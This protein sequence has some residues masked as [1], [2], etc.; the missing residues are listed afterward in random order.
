MTL[1]ADVHSASAPEPFSIAVSDAALADLRSRLEATRLPVQTPSEP[2]G[3]GVDIPYL[4]DLV[5]YWRD[6]FDW[7]RAEI[8]L[9]RVPQFTVGIGGDRVHFAHLIGAGAA[10]RNDAIPII[11]SHGWPYS[12]IEMLP[13]ARMLAE[14]GFE[15]VVPSL[16]GFGLSEPMIEPF[17]SDA[18]A[19]RWNALITAVLG[20][21]RYATYGEDVGTWVSDRL[22]ANYPDSVLGLFATHAAFPPEERRHNLTQ[23]EETFIGWLDA[24]WARASAYS[25]Q[26]STRPDTL[27]VGLT[28]SP[29][30]LAAWLVEKFREWSGTADID[31]YWSRDEMLTTISLYWFTGSIGTS[32]RAYYDDQ[33]ETPMPMIHV[34]VGVSVQH[35]ERGFPRSY[36]ERTY[37]DIRF[38][39][40]MPTGGHFTAKQAPRL[41]AAS[42]KAFFHAVV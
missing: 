5:G 17:V 9:N 11:L 36:A 40:Q 31:D 4:H 24:K 2:W 26:Q 25:E 32:F 13:L 33:F 41:V 7:R 29:A 21:E 19:A 42:M 27:A 10:G 22:A 8:A 12:F 37:S 16:P 14:D 39:S 1:L 18:V 38:W 6:G 30:G 20:Y 3:A 28:D 35:G 34:P 15:V 23:E